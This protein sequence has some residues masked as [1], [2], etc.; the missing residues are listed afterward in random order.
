M[1]ENIVLGVSVMC[2]GTTGGTRNVDW[3]DEREFESD[4]EASRN[5]GGIL[6]STCAKG[7]GEARRHEDGSK[8]G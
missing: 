8:A 3:D 6:V 2:S 7:R 4:K 1:A 5:S